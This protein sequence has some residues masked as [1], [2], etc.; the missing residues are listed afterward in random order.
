ML[1]QQPVV[2]HDALGWIAPLHLEFIGSVAA[3]L[4]VLKIRF[5]HVGRPKV[6]RLELDL[7]DFASQ[8]PI[9][10][11]N[12]GRVLSAYVSSTTTYENVHKVGNIC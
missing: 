7:C 6:T 12:C 11:Q 1:L 2:L 9:A 5:E 4:A 8:S 10:L 3:F